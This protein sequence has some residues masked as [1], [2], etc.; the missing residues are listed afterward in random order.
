MKKYLVFGGRGLVGS[1]LVKKLKDRGDYVISASRFEHKS[2]LRN[3]EFVTNAEI[4]SGKVALEDVSAAIICAFAREAATDKLALSLAFTDDLMRFIK[5][6]KIRNV[7]NISSQSVYAQTHTCDFIDETAE[8]GPS[9][10]YGVAK[11]ATELLAENIFGGSVNYTNIRLAS[12]NMP[13]RFTNYFIDCA[14]RGQS[15]NVKSREQKFSLIDV[16]DVADGLIALLDKDGVAWDSVYNLGAGYVDTIYHAAE[17][18]NE[19]VSKYYGF[20]EVKISVGNISAK[21]FSA[22]D[23]KK[24]TSLTGWMP[25]MALEDVLR[26]MISEKCVNN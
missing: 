10:C 4:F 11:Y 25:R 1:E 6:A 3:V 12:V 2:H 19:M 20:R 24:F 13:Q 21:L 26:K 15:I 5:S 7:I 14:I 22:V 23:N 8:I 16:S 9:D 18:I 17:L